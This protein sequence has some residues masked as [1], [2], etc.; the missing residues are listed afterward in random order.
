MAG[1][2][3]NEKNVQILV[4]L[5]K[6]HNIRKVIVNPGTTHISFAH[7][8][9]NDD[10]FEVYSCIDER[11]TAYMACG[12]AEES[13]EPVVITCT[14]ATASRNY[15]PGLT[16]AFYRKLPVIA[17]TGS[18]HLG[19]VGQNVAQVIDRS[20]VLKDMVKCSITADIVNTKE[21]SWAC[22]LNIN[23]ALLEC[24]H[25]GGGPVHINLVSEYSNDFDIDILPDERK[26]TRIE[27]KDEMPEL[28][29][30]R[31]AIFVGAHSKWSDK[32]TKCVEEFCEKYNA[33]VLCDHTSN[34]HGKYRIQGN[35]VGDRFGSGV[36]IG[37]TIETM[38]HI[39]NVSGAYMVLEPENVWR[40]N[41]DGEI[42]DTFKKLTHVFEMD[43]LD[44][45]KKY[46]KKRKEA[47]GMS[48]FAEW[49]KAKI[50]F[51]QMVE[52]KDL[53]FSN[54]WLA[55]NT[56]GRFPE[57]SI[58]HFGILNTLRSWNF[59]EPRNEIYG[60]ANTGGFGIDG[61]NS[62]LIGSSLNNPNKM[63][64]GIVGDLAFFY[65][66]N[67]LGNKEIGNN[68]RIMLIN[69]GGGGEFHSYRHRASGLGDVSQ[70]LMA[71]DG[72]NGDKSRNLVRHY[73]TDLGFE[74]FSASNKQEFLKQVDHFIYDV[75][76]RPMIFE[77][78]VN[79]D[80]ENEAMRMIDDESAAQIRL[81]KRKKMIKKAIGSKN[82]EKIKAL[83]PN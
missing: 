30:A 32:L 21:D 2:Y 17:V 52:S 1:K 5:L 70:H 55:Q 26:I 79:H 24:R 63:V 81:K 41:P 51:E 66:L 6:K 38:I 8:I 16:E 49:S 43:E 20:D 25:R 64:Y 18:Q 65:D 75:S 83:R 74:Y 47:S 67:S 59:F 82:I 37:K 3:S 39:G 69:N 33:V 15:I 27:Y 71:A 58:V 10:F 73:A 77:M 42:R 36:E 13:G 12:L 35:V 22:N 31:N 40:V 7:S 56:L 46:N 28:T 57:G 68:V 14:G 60:Y 4:S 44:F 80:A 54:I 62:A 76:D 53:P 72:H 78:F 11:S 50:N 34:Y 9:R 29:T 48:Y 45:F 61:N 23:K 19:R